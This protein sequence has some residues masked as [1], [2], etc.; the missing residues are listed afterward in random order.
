M[1]RPTAQDLERLAAGGS[2]VRLKR[3]ARVF[4]EGDV[5][6]A[7]FVIRRGSIG[8]GR[9]VRGRP[10]TLLLLREGDILGDIPTLLQAP[11]A[12]DAVAETDAELVAIPSGRLVATLDQ[13]PE[14]A[15]R[16]VLWLAGR[17][18]NAHSRLLSLLAG[19]VRAQVAALLVQESCLGDTIHL[20]HQSIAAMVGAQ[21]SSVTRALDELAADE[22]ISTGYGQV[23]IRDHD[24][25]VA[26]ARSA[27]PDD[28]AATSTVA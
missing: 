9:T 8:L 15:R 24:A 20:T 6:D 21:R 23:T 22:V 5:V 2:T 13:S 18:S 28:L 12:F 25:L 10:V 11:A 7:V 4:S 17:L 26:A 16:W 14:F 3:G 27:R 1:A 19:D